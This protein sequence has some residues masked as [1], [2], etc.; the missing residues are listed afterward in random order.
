MFKYKRY[1][2]S[3][4]WDFVTYGIRR[5]GESH[6]HEI[7][8]VE[9]VVGILKK[10]PTGARACVT[11]TF[12]VWPQKS[13]ITQRLWLEEVNIKLIKEGDIVFQT[14]LEGVRESDA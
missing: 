11:I 12:Y 10:L 3:G 14:L 1:Y 4:S 6:H 2:V 9:Q 7:R 13:P 8:T 5:K